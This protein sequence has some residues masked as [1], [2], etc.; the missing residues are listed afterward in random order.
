MIDLECVATFL[1]VA[2]HGGFREAAKTAGMSQPAV[3]QHI[4]R[5]EQSLKVCLIQRSNAGCKLT[6]EGQSFLPYARQLVRIGSR[7]HALFDLTS[8]KVGASSNTGIYL[9]QPYLKAYRD[10]FAE[11]MEI[12]IGSNPDIAGKL[13]N[14]EIDVAVMEWWDDRPGFEARLWRREE[15]VLIVPPD[16]PWAARSSVPRDWLKG[17]KLL[18]GEAGTGTARLLRDFLGDS[19]NS[20]GV[21]MQLGSTEAV[22][23]A[24]RAG[25]GI[26]LVMAC[27]VADEQRDQRLKS[28]TIEGCVPAKNLYVVHRR[29]MARDAPSC[30]FS[31]FL[32]S[33]G[34]APR[35]DGGVLDKA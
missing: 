11:R 22:K 34:F 9:L 18:G 26:S 35:R 33:E 4:K 23:H 8:L 28:L 7:A 3:S 19:A 30:R 31:R 21:S 17:Q 27:A 29:D 5:L 24:V 25:L 1:A 12:V 6:P 10:A 13:E 16:H 14:F 20:V 15:L 2:N 32:G